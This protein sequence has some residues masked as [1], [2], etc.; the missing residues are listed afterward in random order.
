VTSTAPATGEVGIEYVYTVVA[1][2]GD[3]GDSLDHTLVAGPEG[4]LVNE[5]SGVLTWTPSYRYLDKEVM[6][7]VDVEDTTG[8]KAQPSHQFTISVTGDPIVNN[9]PVVTEIEDQEA[10]KGVPFKITVV[11][12]D[13]DPFDVL[14]YELTEAPTGM[15]I[16]ENGSIEW[17]PTELGEY[18]VTVMVSDGL[19]SVNGSFKV[20]VIMSQLENHAPVF[21]SEPGT[22]ARV[23]VNYTYTPTVKDDDPG[24]VLNFSVKTGPANFNVDPA[25]GAVTFNPLE[26]QVGNVAVGI[27][28]T[29]GVASA[30]QEWT[31]EVIPAV[32]KPVVTISEPKQG[33]RVKDRIEVKGTSTISYGNVTKVQV[34]LG[35]GG[36]WTDAQSTDDWATWSLEIDTTKVDDGK[37]TIYV[38]A[39]CTETTSDNVTVEVDVKN[40]KKEPV[41][42]D[43][44]GDLFFLLLLIIIIIV[45]VAIAAAVAR[46]RKKKREQ[47][48]APPAGPAPPQAAVGAPPTT[49]P[50]PTEAPPVEQPPQE[51]PPPQPPMEQ[52]PPQPAPQ[53]QPAPKPAPQEQPP[54]QPMPQEQ[55]PPQAQPPQEQTPEATQPYQPPAEQQP[56]PQQPPQ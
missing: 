34:K 51:A 5:N 41:G 25:T 37:Y 7:T 16:D 26:S 43:L 15:T 48:P 38:R 11:A 4:M 46:S 32:I 14:T 44:F 33:D 53:E 17:T 18:P 22:L 54:P 10:T 21:E 49:Q 56:P 19:A 12:T 20:T 6:V 24:T 27:T 9:P 47:P 45:V 23:G 55:A 39:L 36:T 3:V 35:E 50:A 28:V 42:L 29:D 30:D 8:L 2:D 1:E 52:P 31:I 13:E 40:E